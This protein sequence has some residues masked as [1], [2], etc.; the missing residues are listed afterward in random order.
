MTTMLNILDI[1]RTA[2][3]AQQKA[4]DITGRNIANA[5]TEGYTRQRVTFSNQGPTTLSHGVVGVDIGRVYDRY[6]EAQVISSMQ[7]TGRWS[8]QQSGLERIEILFDEASGTG[9]S[10]RLNEFWNAWMD[11]ANLPSGSVERSQL[12]AR[13]RELVSLFNGTSANLGQLQ[14]QANTTIQDTVDSINTMAG[15]LAELN[16]RIRQ[17]DLAGSDTNTL[18]DAR[19]QLLKELSEK[20]DVVGHENE[21]GTLSVALASGNPLVAGTTSMRLNTAPGITPFQDAIVWMDG[22]G[23]ATTITDQIN[24]GELKG[25]LDVRDHIIPDIMSRLDTLAGNMITEVNAVHS[26]GIALDG[27]QND[28]FTGTTAGDIAV[29]TALVN[30]PDKIA[31]AGPTESVPGGNGTALAISALQSAPLLNGGT[32]TFGQFYTALVSDIG[33]ELQTARLNASHQSDMSAS[34]MA[35]RESIS[36][37]SL[38]E[39]MVRLI[40][41][42]HAFE[43]AAQLINVAD[44]MLETVIQM[45]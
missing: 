25:W 17:G 14:R 8:S 27:T 22:Q 20:I 21:D 24:S 10:Q 36:G 28:F 1:G 42:Q 26:A 12:L 44:E 31:A 4:I 9:L 45:V 23:N 2:L 29:N 33:S 41:Y 7:A 37:V 16:G 30:D 3:L 35:Y 11:L 32:A 40:Q 18:K 13:S 43:A 6:L 39:E 34:L 5:D 38:E 15:Q 19:L